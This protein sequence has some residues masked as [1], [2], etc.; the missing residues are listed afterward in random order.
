MQTVLQQYL[1]AAQ[2]RRELPTPALRRDIRARAGLSQAQLADAIGVDRVTVSRW[3]AGTRT[4]R[5]RHLTE[6]LEALNEL[7]SAV[8]GS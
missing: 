8:D 3:E 5:G 6:Y 4:P 1:A 2:R 7:A